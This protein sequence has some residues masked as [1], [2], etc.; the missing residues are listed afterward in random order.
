LS[1]TNSDESHTKVSDRERID[2]LEMQVYELQ[3]SLAELRQKYEQ[4]A[5]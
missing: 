5:E 4:L 2:A 3:L 1:K